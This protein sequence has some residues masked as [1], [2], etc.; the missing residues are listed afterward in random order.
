MQEYSEPKLWTAGFTDLTKAVIEQMELGDEVRSP[1]NFEFRWMMQDIAN[2]GADA[3]FHG[4]IY[5][6][7]TCDFYDA[8]QELIWEAI[9][10]DG[11]AFGQTPMQVI[12]GFNTYINSDM[13][14]KNVLA[15]YALERA[16]NEVTNA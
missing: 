1:H 5:H 7:E 14:L 3:A 6:H 11:E 9:C 8:N 10:D 16:A 13:S 4:F 2:H 15:W 12:A